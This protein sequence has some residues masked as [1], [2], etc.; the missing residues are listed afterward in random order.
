MYRSYSLTSKQ[1][2]QNTGT[3]RQPTTPHIFGNFKTYFQITYAKSGKYLELND[4]KNTAC[5][6][7]WDTAKAK[8]RGK[9]IALSVCVQKE[10]DK[11]LIS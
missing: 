9:F 3:E 6:K 10:K 2:D 7:E 8:L 11:K 5:Q 4:H 1:L